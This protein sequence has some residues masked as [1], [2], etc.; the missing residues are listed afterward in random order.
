MPEAKVMK[1]VEKKYFIS[2][3]FC[4]ETR[5]KS[6]FFF[7]DYDIFY[8]RRRSFQAVTGGP[9]LKITSYIPY[10]TFNRRRDQQRRVLW[11]K[12]K[13]TRWLWNMLQKINW[14]RLVPILKTKEVARGGVDI[15]SKTSN[16]RVSLSAAKTEA[17]RD[18]KKRK[19]SCPKSGIL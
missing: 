17:T 5:E 19:K 1:V 18:E 11:K 16:I 10:N 8:F 14:T 4:R 15:R 12:R 9:G 13:I 7:S 3:S 2:F 6:S